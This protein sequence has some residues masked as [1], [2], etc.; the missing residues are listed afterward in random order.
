MSKESDKKN[1]T[2]DAVKAYEQL[3]IAVNSAPFEKIKKSAELNNR[4]Y[5]NDTEDEVKSGEAEPKTNDSIQMQAFN[6][7][8]EVRE[9][10]GHLMSHGGIAD[11]ES[12]IT[13][14]QIANDISKTL[15]RWATPL[16]FNDLFYAGLIPEASRQQATVQHD[17]TD[18]WELEF[19]T[20]VDLLLRTPKSIL[21]DLLGDMTNRVDDHLYYFVDILR[22]QPE[23]DQSAHGDSHGLVCN[24]IDVLI[25][26]R[27]E[28]ERATCV[29]RIARMVPCWPTSVP[30]LE[31][32]REKELNDYIQS[33]QL[34][35]GLGVKLSSKSGGRHRDISPGST[36]SIAL[37]CYY[38]LENE[39]RDTHSEQTLNQYREDEKAEAGLIYQKGEHRPTF[40]LPQDLNDP[41][42]LKKIQELK[43]KSKLYDLKHKQELSD[44]KSL[45][46][47]KPLSPSEDLS[48]SEDLSQKL[49]G[50]TVDNIWKRKAALLPPLTKATSG[51][52]AD[53]ALAYLA[54]LGSQEPDEQF[55][56][57][58]EVRYRAKKKSCSIETAAKEFIKRRFSHFAEE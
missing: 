9:Q 28:E 36:Y 23:T 12:I 8:H 14:I 4:L 48:D 51:V 25:F 7:K 24:L 10:I 30:A 19:K 17:Q 2:V 58:N 55:P 11:T 34:G 16:Q 22:P 33:I 56:W 13:L 32:N 5:L 6:C 52:W 29:R 3:R 35:R 20:A 53:A 41:N 26:L 21:K 43:E 54:T 1:Q 40:R 15:E 38:V 50:W 27:M 18:E 46:D 42:Y 49:M 31:D 45:S 44:V 39:R 47:V 37:D 57:P